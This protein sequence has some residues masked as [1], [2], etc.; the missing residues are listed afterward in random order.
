M[1]VSAIA[2]ILGGRVKGDDSIEIESIASF[3]SAT[4]TDIAFCEGT[5]CKSTPTKAGC[6]I[7][8]IDSGFESAPAI[9]FVDKPKFSFAIIANELRNKTKP[10]SGIHSNSII[11]DS[12]V[13]HPSVSVGSFCTIEAGAKIGAGTTLMPGS[14]IGADVTIGENCLVYPKVTVGEK[15]VIGDDVVLYSGVVIGTD[16]FGYV[17]DGERIIKFPQIGKVVIGNRVEIGAN[18]CVDRGALSDTEIGDDT[19]I[20]NQV[21]VGHNVSIGRRVL[22]AAHAGISGSVVIED[23][24]VIGGKAGL[25]DHVTIKQGAVLGGG[26]GVYPGKIVPA[27]FWAGSPIQQIRE[28]KKK[29]ALIRSL[30]KHNKEIRTLLSKF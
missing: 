9:I 25:G 10:T 30:S 21:Q 20:D 6:V 4:K 22:I 17:R 16:G 27:G 11:S 1:K 2:K 15:C 13:I 26:S 28:F 18:S 8:T 3:D 23:D 29:E 7:A 19:K 12:A 14:F 24:V 5:T